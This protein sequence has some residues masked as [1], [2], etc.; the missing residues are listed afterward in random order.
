[1]AVGSRVVVIGVGLVG[2]ATAFALMDGGLVS[3]IGLIDVDTGKAEGQAMDLIHGSAFVKP[4][5]IDAGGIS[6]CEGADVVIITAGRNQNPG[7]TRTDLSRDNAAIL[8]GIISGVE[9]HAPAEAVIV[10]VTNPVDV[11]TYAAT[12]LSSRPSSRILG[13]GTVLDSSRFRYMLSRRCGIDPRSVH[14]YIIGEHGDT[15]VASWSLTNVAGVCFEEFCSACSRGCEA[16]EREEIAARVRDSAYHIIEKKGAT[17]WAVALAVRR[18]VEAILRDENSVLTVS[19]LLQGQ[20]GL[21]DVCLSLPSV[22]GRS[23]ARVLELPLLATEKEALRR[24][25]SS[26]IDVRRGMGLT[27]PRL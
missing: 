2:S 1:V 5:R 21:N 24:S 7:E 13:S 4:L 3:E 6:L 22:V 19:G 27:P 15:E 11:L 26:L 12:R 16:V 23:G 10:V 18:I 9:R 25:A 8:R 14:A 20:Y 17:Y